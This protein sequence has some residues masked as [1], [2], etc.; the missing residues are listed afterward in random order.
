[1]AHRLL[2]VPRLMGEHQGEMK[3]RVDR[4]RHADELPVVRVGERRPMR[5]PFARDRQPVQ[6]IAV[7]QTRLHR[8]VQHGPEEQQIVLDLAVSDRTG[9]ARHERGR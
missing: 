8:P 6:R 3:P 1:M 9:D 5:I 7:Q 4:R 2:A